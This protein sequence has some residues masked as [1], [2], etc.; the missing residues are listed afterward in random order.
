MGILGSFNYT[1]PSGSTIAVALM[2]AATVL[3][4]LGA[5]RNVIAG[6]CGGAISGAALA[7]FVLGAGGGD[8]TGLMQLVYSPICGVLG[9]LAG[10]VAGAIGK[11]YRRPPG[12]SGGAEPGAAADRP[13]D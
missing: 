11:A 5:T 1:G 7:W 4:L 9:A 8:L 2:V 6:V 13:R 10:G 12:E 3:L